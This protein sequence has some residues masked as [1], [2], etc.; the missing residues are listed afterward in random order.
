[1]KTVACT[2]WDC[3]KDT[4]VGNPQKVVCQRTALLNKT[5]HSAEVGGRAVV[6]GIWFQ[7]GAP[8]STD[9]NRV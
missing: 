4:Y 9:G 7:S 3:G 2:S 8:L 1:M 6:N 5:T